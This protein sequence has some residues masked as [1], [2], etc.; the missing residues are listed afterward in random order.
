MHT[1]PSMIAALT[2]S[3]AVHNVRSQISAE[4]ITSM[5]A[6]ILA[7]GVIQNLIAAPIAPGSNSLAVIAGSTRFAAVVELINEGKLPRDHMVPVIVR[8]DIVA[9]DVESLSIALT[10]NIMRTNMDFVDECAAMLALA[11]GG[12]SEA[13][14][15]GVFGYRPRTVHER[16]LIAGLIPEAKDLLRSGERT[17]EW[18]RAMTMADATFQT[19][20]VQDIAGNPAS[21]KEGSDI[22]AHLTRATVPSAH[23]LFDADTYTGAIVSDFFEGDAFADVAA[24]WTLQNEAISELETELTGEGYTVEVLRNTPFPDWLYED[25][26]NGVLGNAVVEVMANGRVRVIK[27]KVKIDAPQSSD[28]G[29]LDGHD[30]AQQD[31]SVAAW[32]V[33]PIGRVLDYAQAQK[34]AMLQN[35]LAGDFDAALRYATLAMLGTAGTAF[36]AQPFAFPGSAEIRVG[37]AWAG[38]DAALAEEQTLRDADPALVAT[39]CAMDRPALEKLF[40]AVVARRAGLKRNAPDGN[41][42]SATNVLAKGIDVRTFWTPDAAFFNLLPTPDLRR[43]AA[44]LV[45]HFN[46]RTIHTANRKSMVRS[47]A[48]AFRAA[49]T[50]KMNGPAADRLNT[51]V[52]GVMSFPAIV[53]THQDA[54]EALET[55]DAGDALFGA[56]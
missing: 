1:T 2:L 37:S 51:W 55:V 10:E 50:G 14:I 18:A 46:G 28:T 17:I 48:D 5:K 27:G 39:V 32:E 53:A 25:A 30:A 29:G 40:S 42:A 8:T 41:A 3:P 6:S 23:A 26:P 15:A 13:E 11:K 22:R 38:V 20:V 33:R 54:L 47:L 12:K 44:H 43:L 16:L 35:R 9:G 52:P 31:T 49:A 34:S 19:R 24:F 36:A 21:W 4:S 7:K 56:F 45:P